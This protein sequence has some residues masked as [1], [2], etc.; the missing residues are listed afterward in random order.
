MPR[1]KLSPIGRAA[2]QVRDATFPV[3]E[4]RWIEVGWDYDSGGLCVRAYTAEET[5]DWPDY[6]NP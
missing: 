1:V 4:S 6:G 3:G 5:A 2:V